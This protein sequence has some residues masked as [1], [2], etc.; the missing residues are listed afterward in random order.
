[1][2]KIYK[3]H[4]IAV[5]IALIAQ[6]RKR[7]LSHLKMQKLLYFAQG[8]SFVLFGKELFKEE[9]EAWFHGPVC[10]AIYHDFKFRIP[11]E[12]ILKKELTESISEE[13]EKF[14]YSLWDS[15]EDWSGWELEMLSHSEGPWK[16]FF[17]KDENKVIP[18]EKIKEFFLAIY[19]KSKKS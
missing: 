18:K 19:P 16:D 15:Y 17:K 8:W 10:G 7:V 13:T 3:A 11:F 12:K 6:E 5:Q 14:L 1:M 4:S 9:L 2:P